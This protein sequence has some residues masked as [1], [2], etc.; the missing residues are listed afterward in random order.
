MTQRFKNIN[1]KYSRET[2]DRLIK[3]CLKKLYKRVKF[4][5]RYVATKLSYFYQLKR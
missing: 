5:L 4:V 1:I 2:S 3:Q